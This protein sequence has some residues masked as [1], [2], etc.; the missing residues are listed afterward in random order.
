M[1]TDAQAIFYTICK[2]VPDIFTDWFDPDKTAIVE[3]DMHK[4][5]LAVDQPGCPMPLPRGVDIIEATNA[6]NREARRLGVRVI[7]CQ[8]TLRASGEDDRT[9]NV[10]AWRF[11]TR[12][13]FQSLMPGT[14]YTDPSDTG[15]EGSV[16][17]E[18]SVET[19]PEDLF[20]HHKKR[21]SAFLNTELEFLL[22]NMRKENVVIT[23]L[24]ADACDLSTALD[25]SNRDFR[26]LYPYDITRGVCEETE[27]AA[28]QLISMSV[29]LVV[30]AD[31]ILKEWAARR[32]LL[33]PGRP[34]CSYIKRPLS[35]PLSLNG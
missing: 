13:V 8:L 10:A 12:E 30:R 27:I 32:D 28:A 9:G 11:L 1:L 26:V 21:L 31:D 14:P 22:H 24:S 7:H 29:G 17:H 20:M 35:L 25:A 6:F 18:L 4:S 3:I 2:K 33:P 34:I 5:H 16:W 19:A 15:V 23:G